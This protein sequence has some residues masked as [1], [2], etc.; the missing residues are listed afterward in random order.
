M[1]DH[2]HVHCV[3]H[4]AAILYTSRE[5]NN[6]LDQIHR[7]VTKENVIIVLIKF[8]HMGSVQ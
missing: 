8:I 7:S 2:E 1:Y 3:V 4:L 5:Y 6:K